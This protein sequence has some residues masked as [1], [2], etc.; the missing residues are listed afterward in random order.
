MILIFSSYDCSE[1]QHLV[2]GKHTGQ[3]HFWLAEGWARNTALGIHFSVEDI[4]LG[5]ELN[6][7]FCICG[8]QSNFCVIYKD[9]GFKSAT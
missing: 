1:S 6:V 2:Y 5:N 4:N 7:Y 8:S 3:N 9:V